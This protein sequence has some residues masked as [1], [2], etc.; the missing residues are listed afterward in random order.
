MMARIR[1]IISGRAAYN[2]KRKGI[3]SRYPVIVFESVTYCNLLAQARHE[4]GVR[5]VRNSGEVCCKSKT[6]EEDNDGILG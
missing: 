4:S 6:T 2:N 1:L 3:H 5:R